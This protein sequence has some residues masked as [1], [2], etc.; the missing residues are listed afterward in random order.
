[1]NA[2]RYGIDRET[3]LIWSRVGSQVAVPVLQY[4]KM[5]P[6]NNFKAIYELEIFDVIELVGSLGSVKWTRIVPIQIKNMH[7]ELWKMKPVKI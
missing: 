2:I 7:R 6:E 3:G 1:M 4:D 5:V